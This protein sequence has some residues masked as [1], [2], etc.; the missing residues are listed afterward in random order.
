M[1]K[2]FNMKGSS[3]RLE[4]NHYSYEPYNHCFIEKLLRLVQCIPFL[5]I[6]HHQSRWF[7]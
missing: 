4:S 5:Q 1:K 3:S 6:L 2:H 7:R